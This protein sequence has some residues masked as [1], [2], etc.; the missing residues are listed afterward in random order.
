MSEKQ[1]LIYYRCPNDGRE[2]ADVWTSCVDGQCPSC[3]MKNITAYKYGE[4][5]HTR[6]KKRAQRQKR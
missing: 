4:V 1:F 2:W 5:V 3:G 6:V